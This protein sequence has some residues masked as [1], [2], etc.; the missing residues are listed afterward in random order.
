M[1]NNNNLYQ[2]HNYFNISISFEISSVCLISLKCFIKNEAIG[3]SF[4]K[5]IYIIPC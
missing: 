3:N 5:L 4:W 2:I 1:L